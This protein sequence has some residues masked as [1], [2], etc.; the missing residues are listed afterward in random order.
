[1]IPAEVSVVAFDSVSGARVD[2]GFARYDP[3]AHVEGLVLKAVT[4]HAARLEPD[5]DGWVA[6]VVF[7]V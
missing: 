5:G 3:R 6:Q 7:D 2:V 1:V 4:H